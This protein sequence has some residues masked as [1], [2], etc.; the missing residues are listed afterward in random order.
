MTINDLKRRATSGIKDI[1]KFDGRMLSDSTFS[2]IREMQEDTRCSRLSKR[3]TI[4][5]ASIA[6]T[7]S[8]KAAGI[9]TI[10]TSTEHNLDPNLSLT[11]ALNTPNADYDGSIVIIAT[12]SPTTFTYKL[13]TNSPAAGGAGIAT[14]GPAYECFVNPEFVGTDYALNTSYKFKVETVNVDAVWK[15]DNQGKLTPVYLSDRRTIQVDRDLASSLNDFSQEGAVQFDNQ[16]V[17]FYAPWDL[18]GLTLEFWL[19]IQI[20]YGPDG[21]VATGTIAN[22]YL[23]TIPHRFHERLV[24]GVKYHLYTLMEERDGAQGK[25]LNQIQLLSKQWYDKD[26]PYVKSR[27]N[28]FISLETTA[29]A[30][31]PYIID[32]SEV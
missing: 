14:F 32:P 27:S 29:V 12:P 1:N 22:S 23:E 8:T 26:L 5:S 17:K 19:R 24:S 20:P 18:T 11:I 31:P 9:V 10:T 4:P 6:I 13:G 28:E 25:Y 21:L 2:A 7:S 16:Y 15:V 3:K 30:Y